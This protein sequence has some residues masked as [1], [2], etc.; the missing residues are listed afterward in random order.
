M[1]TLTILKEF[2]LK[3]QKILLIILVLLTAYG[4]FNYTVNK[5]QNNNRI[6]N[7]LKVKDL[8]NKSVLANTDTTFSFY[9]KKQNHIDSIIIENEKIDYVTLYRTNPDSVARQITEWK[10][11]R[12]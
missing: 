6:K 10:R 5:I 2:I 9:T 1:I 7:E 12:N 4:V 3:N 8:L 11:H